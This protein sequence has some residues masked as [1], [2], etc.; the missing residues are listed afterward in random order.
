LKI[1]LVVEDDALIGD[2]YEDLFAGVV[3]EVVDT[4]E[5]VVVEAE[6]PFEFECRSFAEVLLFGVVV[7]VV[8]ERLESYKNSYRFIDFKF[9]FLLIYKLYLFIRKK[10]TGAIHLTYSCGKYT[11]L[12]H[13]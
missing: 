1:I 6:G 11:S 8:H 2:G 5:D 10:L 3:G 9:Y 12:I 7:V 4:V 13:L